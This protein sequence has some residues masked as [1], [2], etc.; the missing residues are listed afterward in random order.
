MNN[1]LK[2]LTDVTLF[3]EVAK[4]KGFRAAASHLNVA[5][6]SVSEAIQRIERRVGARLFDRTTRKIALTSVG[7]M[8]YQKTLPAV[9]SVEQALNELKEEQGLL[10]GVLKLT[11]PRASASLFLDEVITTY[12]LSYPETSIDILYDDKKVDLVT[13]GID[14]AIRSQTLIE[15]DTH[16][17]EVGPELT[18]VLVA[19]PDYLAR[20][21]KP[22]SPIDIAEHN[23]ICFSFENTNKLAPWTFISDNGKA[24]SVMPNTHMVLNNIESMIRFALS[25][26]GLTYVY[27][28]TARPF[29]E[30]GELISIA[31]EC[32]PA[33]PRY[34]INYLT[35]QQMPKRLRAFIDLAKEMA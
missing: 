30:S 8:L 1:N 15:K 5:A 28:R 12:S 22:V 20:H 7:E 17:T 6:G 19:S 9:N 10:S 26:L 33:L 27:R 16:V 35:K 32:I 13:S 11:A 18:M 2:D 25:G 21:G 34:T 24:Y 4:A 3:I 23:G 29:I 14:A 31:E